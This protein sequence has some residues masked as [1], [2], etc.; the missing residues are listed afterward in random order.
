ML[1]VL[2]DLILILVVSRAFWK[3]V[4]GVAAGM[5]ARPLA[6]DPRRAPKGTVHMERDPVCGTFVVPD[7]A[8]VLNA[9]REPLY[10]CSTACR[11]RYQAS[12]GAHA[13]GR[14]S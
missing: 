1:E 2:L 14:A 9:G 10:F 3:L 5:Q 6:D 4:G 13:Q 7:R 11:D 12:S 8:I